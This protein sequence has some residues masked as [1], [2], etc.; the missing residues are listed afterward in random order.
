VTMTV[1]SSFRDGSSA[2]AVLVRPPLQ[3]ITRSADDDGVLLALRPREHD[4]T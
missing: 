2:I 1:R 3:A 4:N